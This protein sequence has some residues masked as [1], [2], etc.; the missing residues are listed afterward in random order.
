MLHETD[1]IVDELN[2]GHIPTSTGE[3]QTKQAFIEIQKKNAQT[4]HKNQS[5]HSSIANTLKEESQNA[6]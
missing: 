5:V 2:M 4:S 6:F 1:Q 3:S